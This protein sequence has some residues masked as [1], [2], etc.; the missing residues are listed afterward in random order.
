[1]FAKKPTIARANSDSIFAN[2]NSPLLGYNS[3]SASDVSGLIYVDRIITWYI[4]F[5]FVHLA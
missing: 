2:D 3:A 1:M 5:S 4:N